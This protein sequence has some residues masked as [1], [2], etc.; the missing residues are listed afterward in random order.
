MLLS[1]KTAA[2]A[3]GLI[4]ALS[5]AALAQQAQPT[6]R[7]GRPAASADT[8]LV[9]GTIDW[10]EKSDVSALR[11]GVIEK[12]EFRVGDRV[13]AGKPIGYLHVKMADLAATKAKLAAENLGPI[14]SAQA[15]KELAKSELARLRRL[16]LKGPF[17]SQSEVE[18]AE[19][20]LMVADAQVIEAKENQ[21]VAKAEHD[22]AKEVVEEHTIRA[23]FTGLVTDRIK[24]PGEAVR[25]NEAV[26]R[27]GRTDQLRFMGYIPL[28]SAARVQ[29]GDNVEV[30][31]TI[32]NAALAIEQKTFPGKIISIS[33]EIASVRKT[34]IQVIAEVNETEDLK[35]PELT[36]RPGLKAEMRILLR[37]P[38]GA[39][40]TVGLK[41]V[42]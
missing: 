29:V 26:V 39:G 33:G 15:K 37:A 11:E 10:I 6:G 19:A 27:L 17:T 5:V 34:D 36:L 23:P 14:K 2:L 3:G 28:E 7:A 21:V 25:A 8:I 24:N 22:I 9:P 4:A 20:E 40:A 35:N 30:R 12:L 38:R 42:K 18:K 16:E 32:D 31:A 1:K 13:E 41:T